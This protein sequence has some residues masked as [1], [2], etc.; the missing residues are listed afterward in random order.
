MQINL[1]V[2]QIIASAQ[3][4]AIAIMNYAD[5]LMQLP[6]GIIG[7]SIGVVL[8]PEL[9]RALSAKNN[10]EI[11]ALQDKSLEFGLGLTIPAA[12]GLFIIPA[13]LIALVYERGAFLRETTEIAAAV[14]AAFAIGLPSF[15]LIKIFQ[16]SFYARQDMKTPMWFSGINALINIA[17][18]LYLFPKM[19]VVGLAIAT[20]IAG[21]VNA[22]L[23]WSALYIGNHY[24]ISPKTLKNIC[25]ICFASIV[26][27][28]VLIIGQNW[29][30]ALLLDALILPRLGLVSGL[31]IMA[32][33]SYFAIVIATGAV[34]RDQ[35][36]RLTGRR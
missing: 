35:L 36:M 14:L 10:P 33:C 17:F 5:R 15:V 26:M 20:S 4:G 18:S 13:P 9:T 7:V 11:K 29:L 19:G 3:E 34:P 2:G 1:L 22:L 24:R 6:L 21:W 8:L 23:L 31:V 28:G 16:P 12:V 27:A 25:L 30:G 32:A